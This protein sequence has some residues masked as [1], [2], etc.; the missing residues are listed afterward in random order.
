VSAL[1]EFVFEHPRLLVLSGAGIST[2]SGIPDYRDHDG[3][4]KHC[5]PMQL[6][7]FLGSEEGRQRYWGRSMLGWP[8][9]ATAVPNAGHRALAKLEANGWVGLLVTQNVDGLHTQAGNRAVVELHGCL[10][11]VNCLGCGLKLAR[12]LMQAMLTALNP[13]FAVDLSCPAPD[14]NVLVQRTDWSTFRV[15]S[16]GSCGGILKPEVVFFGESVPA[17]RVQRGLSALAEAD[18]LLVVG[19]SLMVF[20]GFRFARA[21]AA[22][23]KPVA[24]VN[25]GRTRADDLLAVKLEAPC[26]DALSELAAALAPDLTEHQ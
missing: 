14:G 24:A 7:E 2:E 26:G 4:W 8:R 17:E 1:A 3:A 20:S 25:L 13:P 11:I 10:N 21:A 5:K 9:I 12:S 18:A 22:L 19:S 23:G 15:P 6:Q 16:C